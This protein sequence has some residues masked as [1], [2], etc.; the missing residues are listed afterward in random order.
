M[1]TIFS[2][3]TDSGVEYNANLFKAHKYERGPAQWVVMNGD[4]LGIQSTVFT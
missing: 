3:F 2:K 1:I 4:E